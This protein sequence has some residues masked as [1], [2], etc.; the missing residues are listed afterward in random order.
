M[1]DLDR[2]PEAVATA[3]AGTTRQF[4]RRRPHFATAPDA[5][6]DTLAAW[7]ADKPS[8][9]ALRPQHSPSPT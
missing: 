5:N 6:P 7:S 2:S 9:A 3:A 8:P 1:P 4:G